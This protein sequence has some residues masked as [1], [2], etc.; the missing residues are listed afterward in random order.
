VTEAQAEPRPA[1]NIRVALS[2]LVLGIVAVA[3]SVIPGAAFVAILP[4]VL[5]GFMGIHGIRSRLADRW[6]SVAGIVLAPIAIVVSI[7]TILGVVH[8]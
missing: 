3:L 2:A 7:A 4:A 5:G 8:F 6:Q 1:R